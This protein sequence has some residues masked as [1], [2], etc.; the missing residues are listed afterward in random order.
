[1]LAT[2]SAVTNKSTPSEPLMV[3]SVPTITKSV[4]SETEVAKVSRVCPASSVRFSSP[5]PETLT[6]LSIDK[7]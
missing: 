4:S 7:N 1:M 2:P 6:I 5:K 3:K